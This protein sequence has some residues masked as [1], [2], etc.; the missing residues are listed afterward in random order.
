MLFRSAVL[1]AEHAMHRAGAQDAQTLFS[2]DGG[3]TLRPF[4][5][6][7]DVMSDPLQVYMAVR[8]AGYWAAGFIRA[9]RRHDVAGETAQRVLQAT[10]AAS[11]IGASGRTLLEAAKRS[12]PPDWQVHPLVV[13]CAGGSIGTALES[14]GLRDD[15]EQTLRAGAVYLIQAGVQDDTMAG[16]AH[17]LASAMVAI[18]S[19]GNTLIW[20]EGMKS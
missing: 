2:L 7:Q 1:A 13:D 6:L 8:H 19:R 4:E 16:G 9:A 3:R 18:D 12:L 10:L 17:A 15:S 14:A 11:S 20:Q 5:G